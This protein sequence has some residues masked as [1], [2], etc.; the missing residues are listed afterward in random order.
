MY[1]MCFCY[2]AYQAVPQSGYVNSPTIIFV[3]K[4]RNNPRLSPKE[5]EPAINHLFHLI[6]CL[7]FPPWL[8][9]WLCLCLMFYTDY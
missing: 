5:E 3:N 1:S 6:I 9:V 4:P 2:I 8:F 7:I